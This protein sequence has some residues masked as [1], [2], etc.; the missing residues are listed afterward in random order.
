M[1]NI[2]ILGIEKKVYENI[3]QFDHVAGWE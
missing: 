1:Y 2:I 3:K